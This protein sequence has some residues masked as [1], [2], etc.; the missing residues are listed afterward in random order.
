M[1]P[2]GF[3][4]GGSTDCSMIQYQ[5]IQFIPDYVL[6]LTTHLYIPKSV[7]CIRFIEK[8]RE[9]FSVIF[10][11]SSR[12]PFKMLSYYWIW[13]QIHGPVPKRS[14]PNFIWITKASVCDSNLLLF[15]LDEKFKSVWVWEEN[16]S[17]KLWIIPE[18]K[19]V[20]LSP[21]FLQDPCSPGL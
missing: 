21:K 15:E 20:K 10:I 6:A 14:V 16:D 11:K 5:Y 18:I 3:P 9:P 17:S 4:P 7:C 8:P 13:H 1:N 2:K 19:G 12:V